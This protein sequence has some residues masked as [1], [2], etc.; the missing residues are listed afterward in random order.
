MIFVARL[1]Y[2]AMRASLHEPS[3]DERYLA[4]ACVASFV[5]ILLHSLVDFNMYIPANG[6]VFA[7]IAGIAGSFA[8]RRRGQPRDSSA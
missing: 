3:L 6:F 7:W 1:L 4:V 8:N 5:A 2:R